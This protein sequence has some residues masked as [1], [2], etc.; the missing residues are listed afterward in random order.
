[1][2]YQE[3]NLMSKVDIEIWGRKFTISAVLKHFKN[4][5]ATDKQRNT[6]ETFLQNKTIVD[7]ALGELK[8][9]ILENG[10]KENGIGDVDNIF[11]Y[12]IPKTIYVPQEDENVVAVMCDYKYD[13]EHGIAIVFENEKLKAIG[14]QDVVL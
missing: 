11:K 12:V 14:V 9:Y 8:K 4:E 7:N 2:E 1:M 6:L 10:L 5:E 13:M 3:E